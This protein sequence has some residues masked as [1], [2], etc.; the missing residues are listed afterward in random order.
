MLILIKIGWVWGWVWENCKKIAVS[1]A[2]SRNPTFLK[3]RTSLFLAFLF[4]HALSCKHFSFSFLHPTSFF[5]LHFS[6]RFPY[7]CLSFCLCIFSFSSFCPIYFCPLL[8]NFLHLLIGICPFQ[9]RGANFRPCPHNANA[10]L[11]VCSF[12]CSC[13]GSRLVILFNARGKF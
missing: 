6:F 4:F 8:F 11:F 10:Y 9:K 12:F 2:A 1:L 5:C 7:F 13:S 3:T